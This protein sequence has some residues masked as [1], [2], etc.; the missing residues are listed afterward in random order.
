MCRKINKQTN[1]QIIIF[2]FANDALK[3][4]N[5]LRKLHG[6]PDLTMD[7]SLCEEAMTKTIPERKRSIPL[8][9][10]A[11]KNVFEICEGT[12]SG[13]GVTKQW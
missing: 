10:E 1:K 11:G 8:M 7:Y 2:I 3:M 9:S 5:K 6:A 12:V 4:H 13:A